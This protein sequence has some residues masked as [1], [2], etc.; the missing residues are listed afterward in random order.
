VIS[1]FSQ[2]FL[3]VGQHFSSFTLDKNMGLGWFAEELVGGF[4]NLRDMTH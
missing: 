3:Q 2:L 1:S 4:I